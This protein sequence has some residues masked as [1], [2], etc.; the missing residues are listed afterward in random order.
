MVRT[1][2]AP[3]PTGFLHV[4][5]AYSALLD[6][7]FA[8][9][10]QGQFIIRI[11]DTDLK[12]SVKGAE[13]K[14]YDGLAWL[15]ITADE[16]PHL[17]GPYGPYRQSERLPLY[18]KYAQEL[19]ERGLAYYCFCSP[20]RL[21]RIRLEMQKR[22]EPP[23]YDRC[24]RDI[25]PIEAKK[26]AG[27]QKHVIRLKVPFKEKILVDDLIRGRV[28]FNSKV[29]DD[30]ILLKSDG[31]PTYHLAVV[32]DDHLMKISHVVRGEEWLSSAPKH[33]LLYQYFGWEPPLFLHTPTIRDASRKKL[34]KRL[35][36]TSL[37]WYRE[38][39]YLPE[40]LL[41]F[42]FLLGW[43]HPKEKEI[44]S[45]N[46]FSRHFDL[47]DLS[48]VG[49]IFDLQKL[50]WMNG[51]YIRRK[52]D[53]KLADLLRPFVP[54]G[55]DQALVAKT[56]PLVKERM[57]KLTDYPDLIAFLS[58]RIK[59]QLNDFIPQG[60]SGRETQMILSLIIDEMSGFS[61]SQWQAKRMEK[62]MLEVAD[63]TDWKRG[64]F[65]MVFR[66]AITGKRISPPLFESIAL[67]GRKETLARLKTTINLRQ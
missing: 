15:G 29:I 40:A 66:V 30:Q 11:E 48:P 7:V 24:C 59:P 38:N 49:P 20:D 42:L 26:K 63:S 47:K 45:L 50:D 34:S 51:V 67:L 62:K 5:G 4:G 55:M 31:F 43:S 6:F 32:V 12:R 44:F 64:D 58:K 10:H 56:I 28:V 1:R 60:K 23:M 18:Q 27:G 65:F 8:K 2:F 46:E 14:I 3:S 19:I 39:G 37:D 54:K 25:N 36:H 21:A 22:D 57:K 61:D 41:N 13:E 17:G 16:S 52:T 9:R 33:V 35:G 53:Q